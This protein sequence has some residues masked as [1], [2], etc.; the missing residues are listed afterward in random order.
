MNWW[1]I[2]SIVYIN[3]TEGYLPYIYLQL[4]KV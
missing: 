2:K 1:Q 3:Q 4:I